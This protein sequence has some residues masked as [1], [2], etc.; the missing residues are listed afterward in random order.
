MCVHVY[1]CAHMGEG[2]HTVAHVVFTHVCAHVPTVCMCVH[3]Y[4]CAHTGE[5]VHTV[6][7]VVFTYVR[8]HTRACV[9][10]C[11]CPHVYMYVHVHCVYVC[12]GMCACVCEF[13]ARSHPDLCTE[14]L[15]VETPTG[16]E[17]TPLAGWMVWE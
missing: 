2:V 11:T 6:A 1:T 15:A 3:V 8:T 14:V 13:G 4:T 12:A 16:K 10:T 9:Y 17:R 5:G 7:H